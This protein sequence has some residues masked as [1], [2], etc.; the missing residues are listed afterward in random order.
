MIFDPIELEQIR[1]GIKT[2]HAIPLRRH[3]T[4][5][6][7][8]GRL[9]PPVKPCYYREGHAYT[10]QVLLGRPGIYLEILHVQRAVLA[11]IDPRPHGHAT[12]EDF[13]DTWK[14]R[15]RLKPDRPLNWDRPVWI[16]TF[17][18]LDESLYLAQANIQADYT[19]RRDEAVLTE[20][21]VTG[22]TTLDY[23]H[24]RRLI[25]ERQAEQA[26]FHDLP[27]HEQVRL[28][29]DNPDPKARNALRA[30]SRTVA[31]AA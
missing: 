5:H 27:L 26:D 11:D 21:E 18:T 15:H 29:A 20:P 30:I 31:N 19:T 1:R 4:T 12:L 3:R 8:A 24:A 28:L 22:T 9:K 25:R 23:K 6:T 14:E 13:R 16:L 2:Q 17:K 7:K 10:A